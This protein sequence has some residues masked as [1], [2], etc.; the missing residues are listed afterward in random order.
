MAKQ[1]QQGTSGSGGGMGSR[2]GSGKQGQ[3]GD[4]S[5]KTGGRS[6]D[7]QQEQGGDARQQGGGS[8]RER[9]D[10]RLD[11]DAQS[12]SSPRASTDSPDEGKVG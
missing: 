6:S 1:K 11:A 12:G 9:P 3:G 8:G 7:A 2:P 10:E 4:G 5:P